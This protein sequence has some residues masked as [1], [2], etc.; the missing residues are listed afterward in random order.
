MRNHEQSKKRH[1]HWK[2]ITQ[3]IE[4]IQEI[5][6]EIRWI[7]GHLGIPGNRKA[8]ELV[9]EGINAENWIQNKFI[10]DDALIIAK[11]KMI[12]GTQKFETQEFCAVV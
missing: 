5:K 4:Q 2:T 12:E 3:H 9:K 11:N 8:D 10:L 6:A 7:P 1:T